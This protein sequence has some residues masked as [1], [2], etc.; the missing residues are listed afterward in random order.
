M[1]IHHMALLW[2]LSNPHVST[3]ILGASKESQLKDNLA[4][5]ESRHLMTDALKDKIEKIL[6]NKPEAPRRY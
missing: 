4:A 6:V 3:V 5:L 2:C 1:P